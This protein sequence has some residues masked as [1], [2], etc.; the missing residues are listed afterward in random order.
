MKRLIGLLLLMAG[1]LALVKYGPELPLPVAQA[2][3]ATARPLGALNGTVVQVIDGD[4]IQVDLGGHLETVRYIGVT[5]AS[6]MAID[7]NRRLVAGRE[8]RLELD[9]RERDRE[10]R[11]LA[12]VHVGDTMANAE[13]VARGVARAEA[14]SANVRHREMLLDLERQARILRVGMWATASPRG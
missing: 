6:P 10:G 3:T 4:T 11:L 7:V 14:E 8:A 12:Y 13:L 1:A 2:A 9:L 5:A